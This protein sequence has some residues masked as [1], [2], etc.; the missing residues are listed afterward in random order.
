M[1][2]SDWLSCFPELDAI[3]DPVWRREAKRARIMRVKAGYVL[4]RDGSACKVYV[5]VVSGSVRVGK[6][7]PDGR[8]I[9]LYRV[10]D[11]QSCM[12]TT[13]CLIGH[14]DYPAEGIAETD[15]TLV[16]LP[17]EAF[18]T[19]LAESGEFRSF[20]MRGIGQRIADLMALIEDVAF[21][22]MDVRIAR[23]LLSRSSSSDSFHATHQE[24]SVEL[25][26]AREVVSR[27]L[28]SFE[29]RGWISLGRG[30]IRLQSRNSLKSLCDIVTEVHKPLY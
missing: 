14:Q 22:R 13:T 21:G 15:V 3:T 19:A 16:I 17:A 24:I 1:T 11:H 8:E 5:L 20:V 7:D 2:A 10:E 27:V 28:K 29:R 25:G 23:L 26:T 4:F 12:L 6:M 9:V 18:Q 30:C